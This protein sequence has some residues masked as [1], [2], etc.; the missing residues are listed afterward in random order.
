MKTDI[1]FNYE[2]RWQTTITLADL[3]LPPVETTTIFI[4]H[5]KLFQISQNM[6]NYFK[7][8]AVTRPAPRFCSCP[9]IYSNVCYHYMLL[10]KKSVLITIFQCRWFPFYSVKNKMLFWDELQRLQRKKVKNLS[11]IPAL[12]SVRLEGQWKV[13]AHTWGRG[14]GIPLPTSTPSAQAAD[15]KSFI[16]AIY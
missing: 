15:H 9:F 11:F 6:V 5:W 2:Y 13:K 10:Y 12:P 8:M 4:A 3:Y 7:F 16:C 14:M 1:S